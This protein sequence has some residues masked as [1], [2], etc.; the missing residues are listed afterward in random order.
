M[1]W[2]RNGRIGS[3]TNI[4]RAIRRDRMADKGRLATDA[5]KR[6]AFTGGADGQ[7][8]DGSPPPDEIVSV[9]APSGGRKTKLRG[10]LDVWEYV[11]I[12]RGYDWDLS[13]TAAHLSEPVE[14]V[15]LALD[16]YRANPHEVDER[17]REM[18]EI[19]A[20]PERMLPGARVART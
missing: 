20:D 10:G 13:R 12:A 18:E 16:Y 4:G 11:F 5:P 1:R 15:R 6:A 19:E 2:D 3:R 9:P 17:L 14:R 7:A 8:A